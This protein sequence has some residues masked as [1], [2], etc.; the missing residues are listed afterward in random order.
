MKTDQL[1]G[2]L[3]SNLEAVSHRQVE[4]AI[5]WALVVGGA[6]AYCAMRV[7]LSVVDLHQS[8]HVPFVVVKLLFALSVAGMGVLLL[9]K[10]ARP[11][12]DESKTRAKLVFPFVALAVAGAAE[13]MTSPA[14]EWPSL[15]LGTQSLLCL[16]CIPLF[17]I[18][19][20]ATLMWAVRWGA[21]TDL[22][23][24]GA[25]AGLVAGAL[26]A[27]SYAFACPDHALPFIAIWYSVP[28]ALSAAVGAH[29]GTR[30]L[31]W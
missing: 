2:M 6:L 7:T 15:V 25:V 11:G 28:I 1:I 9:V 3:S 13:V 8:T 18:P 10:S 30:L 22:K 12:Q 29:L 27:A 31:R 5:A 26:G 23:R 24:T 20:F 4:R 16:V 17:A 14:T 19:P 21:P